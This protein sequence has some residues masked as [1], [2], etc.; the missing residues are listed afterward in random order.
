MW[1]WSLG[2]EDPLEEGTATH[3]NILAWRIPWTEESGEL[4]SIES[5]SVGHDWSDL[6][7]THQASRVKAKEKY[8]W[9]SR[10]SWN[11]S[12]KN[13]FALWLSPAIFAIPESFPSFSGDAFWGLLGK[14]M[15]TWVH[16]HT[17]TQAYAPSSFLWD[18]PELTLS[19]RDGHGPRYKDFPLATRTGS[20]VSVRWIWISTIWSWILSPSI[21]TLLHLKSL[22]GSTDFTGELLYLLTSSRILLFPNRGE[23]AEEGRR[24][25][26]SH[27]FA[28]SLLQPSTRGCSSRQLFLLPDL[29]IINPSMWPQSASGPCGFPTFCLVILEWSLN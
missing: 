8:W 9:V 3:S 29:Q 12:R 26:G 22:Y 15:H 1:A 10:I 24:A 7:H 5:Q 17:Y 4:Q 23:R 2:W 13:T 20:G 18:T 19:S 28:M 21:S 11:K 16:M 14:C 27:T 6:A 25:R